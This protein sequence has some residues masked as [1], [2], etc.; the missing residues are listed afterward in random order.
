[1]FACG[2]SRVEHVAVCN[3]VDGKGTH[4]RHIRVQIPCMTTR[5]LHFRPDL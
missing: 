1:M 4:L 3:E 5:A 2:R